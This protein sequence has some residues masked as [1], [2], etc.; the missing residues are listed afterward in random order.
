MRTLSVL[1]FR[2]RIV[3]SGQVLICC[4]ITTVLER[5]QEYCSDTTTGILLP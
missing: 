2:H 3:L 1:S 4:G 5:Q